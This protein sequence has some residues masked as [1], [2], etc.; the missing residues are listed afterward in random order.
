MTQHIHT[1]Q[2]QGILN[3]LPSERIDTE[4]VALVVGHLLTH[5]DVR[6]RMASTEALG[7]MVKGG[8]DIA[9]AVLFLIPF[10]HKNSRGLAVRRDVLSQFESNKWEGWMWNLFNFLT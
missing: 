2:T 4:E 1:L 10:W 7:R 6:M 8:K 3:Y 5:P 9:L